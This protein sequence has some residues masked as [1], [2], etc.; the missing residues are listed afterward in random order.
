MYEEYVL[1]YRFL[2]WDWTNEWMDGWLDGW[3]TNYAL[4]RMK[5]GATISLLQF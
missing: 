3:T 1:C 4:H 5:C 2:K